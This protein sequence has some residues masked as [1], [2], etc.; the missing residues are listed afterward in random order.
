MALSLPMVSSQL[1]AT[2]I[3]VGE[4][5]Q[6]KVLGLTFNVDTIWTTGAAVVVVLILGPLLRRQVTSGV[7]GRFQSVWELMLETVSGQVEGSI[8]PRGA[9]VIPLATTLFV[10]IFVCNLFAVV[11]LGSRYEWLYP[12]NADINLPAAM[13]VY[14]I[15]LVHISSIRARGI[16]G[17][18]K[19]YLT[20]PFPL[21]LMPFNL[22][23]NVLEE[24]SKPVTLALRLFG[25]LLSGTLMLS[26]ITYLGVWKLGSVP[27]GNVLVLPLSVLWRTFDLAIGAIQAFIFALLTILYFDVAMSTDH[28]EEHAHGGP[29]RVGSLEIPVAATD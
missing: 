24:L 19:H 1:L 20:Q 18:L 15:V 26:L 14:V 23:I 25:N 6:K 8:G 29:D 16:V 17:Y 21:F 9:A 22:F 7:P 11:G 5:V 3:A 13:A 28:D 2:S 10:F 4:H 27:L 12:P